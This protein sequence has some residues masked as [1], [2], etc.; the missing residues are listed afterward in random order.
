MFQALDYKVLHCDLKPSNVLLGEDTTAYLI[1][2][3]IATICFENL[4]DS[5]LISTHALKGSIGYTP[6]EYGLGGRVTTKGDVYSYGIMLLEMLTRKKPTNN[7]VVEGMHFQKWVTSGFSNRI[8]EVVDKNLL[9]TCMNTGEDKDLNC[10]KQCI[11]VGLRCTKESPEG[12]PTMMN[13]VGTLQ[14]I[15]E[16]FLGIASIPN[17][18]SDITHLLGST[19]YITQNNTRDNPSSSTF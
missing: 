7:M 5:A 18:Q 17:F 4:K 3:G 2:F 9:R 11:S 14:S 10:L 8:G 1:D 16:T 15:R 19:S 6:P 12:R 13:I